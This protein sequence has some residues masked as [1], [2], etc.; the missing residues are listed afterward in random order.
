VLGK[1]GPEA[2][3]AVPALLRTLTT[4]RYAFLTTNRY[5]GSVLKR[6][7]PDAAAKA[8]VQ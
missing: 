7:D 1:Y 5:A 4:N 6:I 3:A 2:R 8:G